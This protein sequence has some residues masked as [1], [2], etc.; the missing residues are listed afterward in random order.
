M[1]SSEQILVQQIFKLCTKKSLVIR[2]AESCTGGSIASL[3]TTLPGSSAF[4]DR[5]VVTY[6]NKAKEEL[7]DIN[8]E[9]LDRYGAVSYETAMLMAE[10]LGKADS[11]NII[12]IA[13]TGILGPD[14]DNTN[15]PVGLVYIAIYC[16]NK[17]NIEKL[18]LSGTRDT[19]KEKVITKALQLCLERLSS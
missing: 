7:L 17:T 16:N 12:S 1:K 18:S 2:T 13:T 11:H 6:S 9:I 3:L 8:P 15:K 19:I 14:S 4:F 10:N 5:G